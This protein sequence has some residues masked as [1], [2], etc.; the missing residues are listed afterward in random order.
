MQLNYDYFLDKTKGDSSDN[1]NSSNCL[2][3]KKV[4]VQ[5]NPRYKNFTQLYYTVGDPEQ[6]WVE[7]VLRGQLEPSE[8]STSNVRFFIP[9]DNIFKNIRTF[10]PFDGYKNISK[11]EVENTFK[12]IFHKFKKG[13]YIKII[14]GQL[15]AFVPFSKAFYINEWSHLIKIDP[16]YKTLENFFKVH[17]DLTNKINGTYY[18]F[19]RNIQDPIFWYANNCILRYENPINEGETNY[20]QLKSMFLELCAERQIPDVEF[21]V[22]KR[23]FPLLTRDGTEPYDNIYGPN[24][25]LKS[26]KFD[27]YAPILSMCSSDKFADIAIPTHEDWARIKSNEGVVFPPKCRNYRFKFNHK[28][29]TKINMAVFRGSNTGCGYNQNNNTRLKLAKLG[30]QHPQIL[31]VG[32]TNWNMRIRKNKGSEYLQIPDIGDLKLVDKLTPE[33]QSNYKFL[34]NVD[35][36]VSAFRLSLELS[37]GCCILMVESAEKWKL[38]FSD[39]LEPYVHYV[40][41]KSDL[42]DLL[43]QLEWCRKNDNKCKIMA[44]NALTFYNKY[45]TKKGVLDNLQCTLF[46]LNEDMRLKSTHI[47]D[48]LLFLSGMEHTTLTT[49]NEFVQYKLTGLFPKNI[50]RNYGTLKA[51]ENFITESIRPDQQI[52]MIGVEGQTIFKSKTTKVTLYHIGAEYVVGKKTT[53]DMKRVEFVHEAFIG[54]FVVNNLLKLC[55]NFVFTLGYRDE[56][57]VTVYSSNGTKETTV[58]Q[59]YIKGPTLQEFLR[60]CTFKS[61][62]EIILAL[63]CALIIAQTNYG[64]VHHDLKPWNIM[65]N[66]LHEPIIIE[67]YF[68]TENGVDVAYKI[69]TK[70]VPVIVDYGKSHVIYNNV[71]YGIVRPFTIDKNID[72]ITLLIS[73][74]NEFVLRLSSNQAQKENLDL[75]DLFYMINFF[76]AKKVTSIHE[77]QNFLYKNKKFNNLNMDDVNLK[78]VPQSKTIFESF[79]KYVVPLTRKYKIS[80]GK[81]TLTLNIWSSNSRQITDMGFGIDL[82]DKVDSYLEVVKRIYKNPMPQAT[83]KF[84]TIMIAQ[85]M[86]DG[87]IAPKMEF[88]EF[89]NQYKIN[90]KKVQSILNKFKKIENFLMEFYT[91]QLNKKVRQPIDLSIDNEKYKQIL[92]FKLKPTRELFLEQNKDKVTIEM[93][94]LPAQFIDYRYYRSLVVNVLRNRGPFQI[95][96]DDKKFYM[97]NFKLLFDE[98][99]ISKVEDIETIR[100]FMNL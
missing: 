21:F 61:Y 45:L 77:L 60:T 83:N 14:N 44:Q 27:K 16:K 6:F 81:D 50:G 5:T 28:W 43:A 30:A 97:D 23:D 34:I 51:L 64:F 84:T 31:D 56:P 42:S 91:T 10:I 38:W 22:N 49:N 19:N 13:I 68:R 20:A 78:N 29:S 95:H 80:F 100:F 93:K 46:K 36:H 3:F 75:N 37:M 39:L 58:L 89:A 26:Y 35:G 12:Y 94:N 92:S 69:R 57:N 52:T 99:Y 9:E 65:V 25:P 7:T 32:I 67:Y 53:D 18:K 73:T 76:S 17:H 86:F 85:R 90:Q 2:R 66:I 87:L 62:L 4:K 96:E 54:K 55:P 82:E 70:Y 24:V 47:K 59:E 98:E 71:H 63:Q 79:F 72:L 1:G 88:I 11:V 41:I 15:E 48:P 8:E 33:Q 40:P 74:I